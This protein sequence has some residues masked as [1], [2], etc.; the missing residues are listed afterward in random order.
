[1]RKSTLFIIAAII[2]AMRNGF[3]AQQWV[4][5]L[6]DEET[7]AGNTV[8]KG[9]EVYRGPEIMGK[10][11]GVLGVGAVGSRVAKACFD[12]G[13]NVIGYDPYL[14]HLRKLE[15]S[16]YLRFTDNVEDIYKECDFITVHVPLDE[17]TK[18]MV[19]RKQIEMM[20]DGVYL[21][22][23]ARG[24]ILDNDAVCD[25]LD[26]GKI[27]AFATDFPTPRRRK[28]STQT[29]TAS[30]WWPTN[31]SP[32]STS[33]SSAPCM[34]TSPSPAYWP[35][36][37]SRLNRAAPDLGKLSEDLFVL[38]FYNTKENMKEAFDPFYTATTLAEPTDVNILHELKNT[39]LGLGVFDMDE[40]NDFIDL[41][42][43]G[44]TADKWAP[45]IDTAAQRFNSEIEWPENGKAD[46]KMKCKQ[47]V[48][49][50]SR[51]A[52]ILNFEMAEW[53]K[54][55]WFLRFLIPQLVVKDPVKD[56]IKDLL[57]SVDLNTYGLR[58]TALNEPIHLDPEEAA[59][60]PLAPVMVNAGGGEEETQ[61]P[62]DQILKEFNERWFKGWDAA[63]DDQKAKLITITQAVANDE[64]YKT[65]VVGNPDK[66]AVAKA[67]DEIID[68]II[69]QQRRGDMSLYKQYQQNESFKYNFRKLIGRMLSDLDYLR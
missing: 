55:F 40:V 42:I 11:I 49:I 6:P 27:K 54:L 39:I 14:S 7:I 60:N 48:K 8:E 24:P 65:L 43:H 53:E 19:G 63:P 31:T 56:D 45:I 1:M 50:Y 10:T 36:K 18:G 66:Q 5:S 20:K 17:T 41:Y 29:T 15:L 44:A 13:M 58:R 3:Q 35:C 62:L 51:V 34:S 69:R 26:S 68:K 64:D 21:I 61:D 4:R 33:P 59:L 25:A 22:N 38:D 57:D 9:K 16:Q 30:L 67:M 32:A 52:A 46:F 37:L 2:M 28:N 23:Y 47:F 12:L